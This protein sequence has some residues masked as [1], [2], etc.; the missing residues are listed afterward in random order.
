MW[1]SEGRAALKYRNTTDMLI[2]NWCVALCR[3]C[4]PIAFMPIF[5]YS[6][7]MVL[8]FKITTDDRLIA[9]YAGMITSA[10]T[11]AEFPT[12]VLWEKLSDRLGR[13]PVLLSGQ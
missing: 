7:H 10:F 1:K 8:S 11:F 9:I 13:K 12:S 4:E 5:P 2:I 3:I 6:Y